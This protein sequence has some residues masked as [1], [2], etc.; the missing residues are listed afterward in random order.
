[1]SFST[2]IH[3]V[4]PWIAQAASIV[5]PGAAP[6]IGIAARCLSTGLATTVKADPQSISDAITSAMASPEQAAK[7][8]QIDDD[9][10]VQMRQL[11]FQEI[12]DLAKIDA[13]DRADARAMQVQTKS[14]T[15]TMLAWAAVLTLLACIYMLGFRTLPS[16]GHDVLMML[17]GTVAATYK[18]VYGYFF[19]SSAGSDAKTAIIANQNS[20]G[21]K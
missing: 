1:M 18:D 6:L 3:K 8:K 21:G 17:L 11:G 20:T 19:G 7:L 13:D 5:A 16:T 2:I 14:R 9:F 15:P 10:S 4:T 12:E